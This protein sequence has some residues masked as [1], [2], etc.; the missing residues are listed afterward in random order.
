M[1]ASRRLVIALLIAAISSS[2]LIISDSSSNNQ[3][4]TTDH[5]I[6]AENAIGEWST[7]LYDSMT[8]AYIDSKENFNAVSYVNFYVQD[9]GLYLIGARFFRQHPE[10]RELLDPN[11]EFKEAIFCTLT[12]SE[13]NTIPNEFEKSSTVFSQLYAIQGG[14]CPLVFGVW[15]IPAG[16]VKLTFKAYVN[17]FY[18]IDFFFVSPVIIVDGLPS[19]FLPLLTGGASGGWTRLEFWVT[20]EKPGVSSWIYFNVPLSGN[21]TIYVTIWHDGS[22]THKVLFDVGNEGKAKSTQIT[23][24][25][26]D[27]IWTTTAL[28]SFELEKGRVKITF[29][30]DSTNPSGKPIM[31]ESFLIF[32]ENMVATELPNPAAERKA[33]EAI[34]EARAAITSAEN[35]GRTEGLDA[36]KLKLSDTE[37]AFA[38]RQYE[39]AIALAKEAKTLAEQATRLSPSITNA[40]TFPI[41]VLV[42]AALTVYAVTRKRK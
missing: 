42:I 36:A 28:G 7:G 3:P 20:T 15:H 37:D 30:S 35:E 39:E 11:A 24:K 38:K 10:F 5:I 13:G 32:P 31:I 17:E 34:E 41:V 25:E 18:A 40:L 26:G 2:V 9:T 8:G 12:D 19:A 16:E 23:L 4:R 14:L 1:L 22:V 21:Y 6:E 33:S 27:G 29:T